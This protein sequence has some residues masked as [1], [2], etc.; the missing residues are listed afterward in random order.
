M[1]RLSEVSKEPPQ[2]P[3]DIVSLGVTLSTDGSRLPQSMVEVQFS[4]R[5]RGFAD[6]YHADVPAPLSLVVTEWNLTTADGS[7][8]PLDSLELPA[9]IYNRIVEAIVDDIR[10]RFPSDWLRLRD[11][12]A[13][14]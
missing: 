13:R 5:R 4:Y 12:A 11:E 9:L 10:R 8:F 1:V 6:F 7:P 3:D 14:V 2:I